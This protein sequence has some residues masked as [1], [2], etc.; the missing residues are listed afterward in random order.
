[1]RA[2]RF[3]RA[4]GAVA[5]ALLVLA[6]SQ[7]VDGFASLG[8]KWP[9]GAITM[10]LQLAGRSGLADGSAS[11]NAV[12][13]NAMSTW[14]ESL[15]RVRFVGVNSAS[16]RG[17]DG[18]LINQ[19]F[20]DS[21]YYGT[22]FDADVLA[23][24]TRWF[25]TDNP[26]RRVEAD[27]VFNSAVAFDSYRGNIRSSGVWDMRRVALHELGHALGLDHP[28]AHGQNVVA[29]MNTTL[30]NLDSLAA[31]DIAGAQSLYGTGVAGTVT[32]PPRNEPNDFFNQLLAVYQNELRAAPSSTY[33]DSE[34]AVIWLT[35]YARQRVGQCDHA[36]ASDN[37]LAQITGN[38]GTLVCAATP[39]GA[40]PFPP[41]NEGLLF[42]NQLDA[43]YRDSLHRSLGSSVVNNEG[44]VV[45][46]L[47]YL[48]Y[49]LNG[50][51][52]GDATTKVLQQI[53]GQGIQPVCTA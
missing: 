39:S 46:V 34:G 30:G 25:E 33:L 16:G 31:D 3:R 10:N 15:S 53:R 20:S 37:T 24:T 32:F 51:N 6:T 26:G 1:M 9:T 52:H 49:R 40:I 2:T 23:I 38:A 42:M 5:G 45:W 14:N 11:F 4:L 48:R 21:T 13:A 27:I 47:E 44:A 36:T 12:I 29:L 22:R 8:S 41:R 50:C 28:D 18:D 19:V 43:T 17:G 35:E 7:S